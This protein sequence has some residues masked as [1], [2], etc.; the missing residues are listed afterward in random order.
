M[1]QR[2]LILSTSVGSGH[3]LAAAA[4]EKVFHRHPDVEVVNQDALELTSE[5]YRAITADSYLSM[6]KQYP[7]IIGWLYDY[8]DQPFVN[9]VPIRQ[10]FDRINA[11]RLVAFIKDFSPD[12]AVCTH[13]MPAGIIAHLMAQGEIDMSLAVV[14]TDYD[15]QGMWLSRT[16]NH[17][18]V[19]LEESKAFLAALGI[20]DNHVTVSGI[21]VDPAFEQPL[22]REAVLAQYDLRADQPIVLVSAGAVGGGPAREIVAQLLELRHEVQA[23]VVCGKN[24]RLRGDVEALVFPQAARFR[25]LGFTRDMPNLMRIAT[26]FIGKPGGL[27]ASECMAAELPMAIVTP[28]PGQEE[29]NSDHL[30][31][32]GAAVRCNDIATVGFKLDRLFDEPGRIEQMRANTRKLGRPDAARTIVETLLSDQPAQVQLSR[33][34]RRQIVAAARGTA[35]PAPLAGIETVALYDERTGVSIGTISEAQLRF[36]GDNL[37]REDTNDDDYYVDQPT[38]EL[39]QSRGAD[40][41]LLDLLRKAIAA[42]G[43]ADIRWSRLE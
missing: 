23:V 28:I 39:L 43:Q 38:I 6:A 41:Q 15:F 36:L 5:A 33:E 35:R 4:L 19:A 16:F 24:S 27:T 18:F 14:T 2:V 22:D 7:W 20:S 3:K 13:F 12:I 11:Q 40:E 17:Y 31:E 9:E 10:M 37:E 32:E 21:P 34:E 25:V 29:R 8:N 26:L 30:L 42:Q 1:A